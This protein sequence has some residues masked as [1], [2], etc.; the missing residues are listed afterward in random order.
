MTKFLTFGELGSALQEFGYEPRQ[1]ANH[2]VFEHPQGRLMIVLPKLPE[3][4]EVIP[5]HRKIVEKT[6]QDDNI[7]PWDDFAYYLEHGKR[8]EEA[9]KKGDRLIWTDPRDG[10]EHSVIAAAGEQD[11]FV[12]IKQAWSFSPCPLSELRKESVIVP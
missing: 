6:I 11:G 9:I 5:L 12:V 8:Q 7:V 1:K 2:L 3:G 10:R 4:A